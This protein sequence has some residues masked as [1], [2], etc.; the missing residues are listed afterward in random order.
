MQ[1]FIQ[2][3]HEIHYKEE[4]ILQTYMSQIYTYNV[5]PIDYCINCIVNK[6]CNNVKFICTIELFHS[7]IIGITND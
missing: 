5:N 3:H 7:T 2:L 6:Y 1:Q 4:S